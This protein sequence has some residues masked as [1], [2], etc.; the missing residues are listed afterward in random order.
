MARLEETGL[1]G[2]RVGW[3]GAGL[4]GEYWLAR[5]CR[6][7]WAGQEGGGTCRC[8]RNVG[9]VSE[10]LQTFQSKENR[11]IVFMVKKEGVWAKKEGSG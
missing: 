7:W 3:A 9:N 6:A 4:G 10:K 8:A 5:P 1:D 11:Q 2:G